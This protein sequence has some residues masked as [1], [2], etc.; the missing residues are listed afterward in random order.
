MKII[1]SA[2]LKDPDGSNIEVPIGRGTKP[3][4]IDLYT[5]CREALVNSFPDE[6][7]D[8]KEIHFAIYEQIAGKGQV[9]LETDDIA[10]LKK[11][12]GRYW[13]ALVMGAAFKLIEGK[14]RE[15][16]NQTS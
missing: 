5:V 13:G 2:K 14:K 11:K 10:V 7:R 12:I 16:V 3:Q 6:S 15:V 1:L 4:P 9:D 8:D